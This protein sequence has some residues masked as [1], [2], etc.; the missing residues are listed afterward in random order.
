MSMDAGAPGDDQADI[1][2]S[3][4]ES[5]QATVA[6]GPRRKNRGHAPLKLLGALRGEGVLL[7]SGGSATTT[8]ELDIYGR[9]PSHMASGN[10]EGDFSELAPKDEAESELPQGC[11]LRLSDGREIEIELTALD[12]SAAGFEAHD[13]VAGVDLLHPPAV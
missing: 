3:P 10:L 1:G 2:S 6:W 12:Q 4:R 7:W 8:Y 5:G 11:R 13:L 9:G